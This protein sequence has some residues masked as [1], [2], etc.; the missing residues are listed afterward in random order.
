MFHVEQHALPQGTYSLIPDAGSVTL[1]G[2]SFK[3]NCWQTQRRREPD[4]FQ[5]FSWK[6]EV[7]LLPLEEC[8]HL[9]FQMFGV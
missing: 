2:V 4:S 1:L 9:T 8:E 6:L 5:Y 3:V 7:K